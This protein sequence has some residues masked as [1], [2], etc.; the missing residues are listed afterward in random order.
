M[1]PKRLVRLREDGGWLPASNEGLGYRAQSGTAGDSDSD[2][3]SDSGGWRPTV[4]EKQ[5]QADD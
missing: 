1:L 4:T 3:D 5:T 2:S